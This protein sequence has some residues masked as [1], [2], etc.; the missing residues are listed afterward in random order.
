MKKINIITHS[1]LVMAKNEENYPA[2]VVDAGARNSASLSLH[3]SFI[4]PSPHKNFFFSLSLNV[5]CHDAKVHS[6]FFFG[7]LLS[8]IEIAF[9]DQSKEPLISAALLHGQL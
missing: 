3:F 2:V 7:A 6:L 9:A 4:F 1:R 8:K 5:T